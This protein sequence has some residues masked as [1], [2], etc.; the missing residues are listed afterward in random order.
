VTQEAS[1]LAYRN[2]GG[3]R[4]EAKSSTRLTRIAVNLC[5]AEWRKR[6]R[7]RQE[8]VEDAPEKAVAQKAT[9][10]SKHGAEAMMDAERKER[11]DREIAALPPKLRLTFTKQPTSRA[12]TDKTR[13]RA[14]MEPLQ[15]SRFF[16]F[17]NREILHN[18]LQSE[19]LQAAASRPLK[20]ARRT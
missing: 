12:T 15:R 4:G 13:M 8:R 18:A 2:L 5:K 11:I 3:F 6:Q 17:C 7:R 20:R 9:A 10:K 14:A 19:I 16:L 1:P